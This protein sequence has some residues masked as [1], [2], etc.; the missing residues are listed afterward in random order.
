[1]PFANHGKVLDNSDVDFGHW[2]PDEGIPGGGTWEPGDTPY[3]AVMVTTKRAEANGNKLD[4][5]LAP[6]L[7]LGF[8]N[9]ETS[10]VA[11]SK[12]PTAWDVALVQD[13]TSSFTMEIDDARTADQALLDCVSNNFINSKM[14]LTAFTGTSHIMTPMLPVGLNNGTNYFAMS[15]AITNLNSCSGSPSDPPM[16]PCTGTHV[17][18]GIERAI[19]QLDSY[20][21]VEGIIGQAIVIVGDGKPNA[22]DIAQVFYPESDYYG[23]CGGSCNNSELQQMANLAAD[24]AFGKDYDVYVLF[25]DENNDD[26]AAAFFEGLIRGSGQFRRT[27]NS[28]EL[29]E[30]MFDLCTSF[31]DLQLVM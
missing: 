11:Y 13:V 12:A 8:L 23:V 7:G 2:T 28:D 30:L 4:L 3:N 20:T 25:Y 9:I 17:G 24:E 16:P 21:P 15:D 5:A 18:I 31:M 10:A 22:R 27:P 14:G 1:M 19:D 29:D 26:A 6:I